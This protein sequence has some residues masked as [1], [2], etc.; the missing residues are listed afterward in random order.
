MGDDT[1]DEVNIY[2]KNN[3]DEN[4][5]KDEKLPLLSLPKNILNK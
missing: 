3:V 5:E 2:L 4:K 1:E